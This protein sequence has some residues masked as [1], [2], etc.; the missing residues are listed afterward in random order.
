MSGEDFI[1]HITMHV[2]KSEVSPAVIIGKLFM[3]KADQMQ[4][5]CMPV[6]YTGPPIHRGV[7]VVVGSSMRETGFYTAPANQVVKP[8]LL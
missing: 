4:D 2:R 5:R 3:I 8:A 6:V 1:H 7:T